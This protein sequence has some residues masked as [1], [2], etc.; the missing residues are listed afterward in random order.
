MGEITDLIQSYRECSRHVWNCH[1][2]VLPEGWHAFEVVDRWL[3]YG[4]VLEQSDMSMKWEKEWQK[5]GCYPSI[6]VVPDLATARPLICLWEKPV[7]TGPSGLD[8]TELVPIEIR[9]DDI[10]LAFQGFH[11][12]TYRDDFRDNEFIRCRVMRSDE[13]RNLVNSSLLLPANTVRVYHERGPI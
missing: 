7:H 9:R 2:R 13:H 6:R 3:L 1:F 10:G 4:I 5:H 8:S 12:L 11:D